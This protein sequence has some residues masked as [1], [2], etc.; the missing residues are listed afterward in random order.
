MPWL[1]KWSQLYFHQL[2]SCVWQYGSSLTQRQLLL[3]SFKLLQ[4]TFGDCDNVEE[5]PLLLPRPLLWFVRK[6]S[7]LPTRN[8]TGV[9]RNS[10]GLL[11]Y[12]EVAHRASCKTMLSWGS[13]RR[14][15]NA[16]KSKGCSSHKFPVRRQVLFRKR[17]TINERVLML[18]L[19]VLLLVVHQ[20]IALLPM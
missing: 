3:N 8:K 7:T 5:E 6:M 16:S 17:L 12:W 20:C 1:V 2:R 14:L 4:P 10:K 9:P 13:W 19:R 15:S 18:S 11:F